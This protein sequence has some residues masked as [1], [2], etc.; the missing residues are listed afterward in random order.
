MN[1]PRHTLRTLSMSWRGEAA[2]ALLCLFLF[3]WRLGAARLF[4]MDEGF[5]VSCARQ[6]TIS[7]DWITPR[8]NVRPHDRPTADTVPF[9]EKPILTY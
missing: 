5:Y 2:L 6:M 8:L 3:F 1:Q 7:G 4:D 9:F